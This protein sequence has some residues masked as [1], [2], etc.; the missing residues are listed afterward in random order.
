MLNPY[1]NRPD[2][3]NKREALTSHLSPATVCQCPDPNCGACHDIPTDRTL[4]N[5]KE[6][7]K[8]LNK[9]IKK[10][11]KMPK[12]GKQLDSHSKK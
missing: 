4:P 3:K 11:R 9:S 12:L 10:K 5:D 8:H 2:N 6:H 7:E 1:K